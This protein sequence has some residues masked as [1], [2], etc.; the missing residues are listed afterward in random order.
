MVVNWASRPPTFSLDDISLRS[1]EKGNKRM[2]SRFREVPNKRRR[3]ILYFFHLINKDVMSFF[4][5]NHCSMC[6]E[7]LLWLYDD[8][9]QIRVSCY[10]EHNILSY[11]Q[12]G[13]R[14]VQIFLQVSWIEEQEEGIEK[15]WTSLYWIRYGPY[16]YFYLAY[17]FLLNN[18][19]LSF[20]RRMLVAS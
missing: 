11:C 10:T 6:V 5:P 2:R 1:L 19:H 20:N 8:A 13:L 16:L 14:K 4:F 12:F 7:Y 18:I 3:W 9:Y 15:A 17:I